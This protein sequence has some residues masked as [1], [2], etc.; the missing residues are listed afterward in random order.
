MKRFH[1]TASLTQTNGLGVVADQSFQPHTLRHLGPEDY[2][3]QLRLSYH[4]TEET[5]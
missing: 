5:N 2:F 1:L 3:H 4:A